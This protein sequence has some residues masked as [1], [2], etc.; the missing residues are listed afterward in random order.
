M[1]NSTGSATTL[2]H[3]AGPGE[4][5]LKCLNTLLCRQACPFRLREG[6]P[7]KAHSL[8]SICIA[9]AQIRASIVQVVQYCSNIREESIKQVE[10]EVVGQ[11]YELP[12][13]DSESDREL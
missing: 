2:V 4:P 1:I 12:D 13:P 8:A 7:H 9:A 5:N 11:A 10:N 3:R 6:P